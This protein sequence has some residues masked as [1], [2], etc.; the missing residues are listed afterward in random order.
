VD[1][2]AHELAGPVSGLT[3]AVVGGGWAGLAAAVEAVSRGHRVTLFDTAPQPG[4]RARSF[5]HREQLLDNGQHIMIGAYLETLGLM[6]RVG[7]A[8][9]EALLR[10]PLALVGPDGQGLRL[11]PG[12]P[13]TAFM[14]GVLGCTAWP[15]R[16]RHALLAQTTRWLLGGF[17]CA[18]SMTVA[19]LT[20]SLPLAVREDLVDPLCVAALNTPARSA[21]AS[22]FLRVLKDGLFGGP[23][24]ADLLLPRAPLSEL[25][26]RP[27]ERWLRDRGADIRLGTRVSVL[28]RVASGWQ[29]DGHTFDAVVLGCS[30][31]EAARL[32]MPFAA[33]WAGQ[34]A[35]LAYEPIITVYLECPGARLRHPMTALRSTSTAPAQFVF[36]HGALGLAPGRFA[37]VVSGAADWAARGLD[38]CVDATLAQAAN[39]FP[40]GTWPQPPRLVRAVTEKRATFACTPGLVRPPA[41]IAP[42]LAA[43]GDYVEGPYPATLEGAVRSGIAAARA[44]TS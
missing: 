23:G 21:S 18:P 38:A 25:L 10:L 24:S 30:A 32:T 16:A 26:P 15:L 44:L 27:A 4:G 40:A 1:R 31:Q 9:D 41:Q 14:R 2:D 39:A 7:V 17:R 37:F 12:S 19:Q 36:D 20:Q 35:A 28:Q 6:Q 34:A 33:R 3:L 29:V 22:V 43:A 8:V 5:P 13:A 11:P 42:Q